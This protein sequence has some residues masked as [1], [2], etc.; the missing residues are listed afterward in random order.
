MCSYNY[1]VVNLNPKFYPLV[2]PSIS[3]FSFSSSSNPLHASLFLSLS[4]PPFKSLFPPAFSLLASPLPYAANSLLL[5]VIFQSL[6]S[7]PGLLPLLNCPELPP[8][9][10]QQEQPEF[11]TFYL[12]FF[13]LQVSLICS[14]YHS[15]KK[16]IVYNN[17]LF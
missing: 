16:K 12:N 8:M 7:I 9:L 11:Y 5:T 6:L 15:F 2:A 13:S 3:L 1:P 17:I 14:V 4:S 10:D